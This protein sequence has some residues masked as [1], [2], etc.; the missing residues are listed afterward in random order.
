VIDTHKVMSYDCNH[1][2]HVT[3]SL[4]R[5][6]KHYI[7]VLL[8]SF[9]CHLILFM[10]EQSVW[11]R[12]LFNKDCFCNVRV[13]ANVINPRKTCVMASGCVREVT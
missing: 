8:F 12:N 2:C 9:V 6:G 4:P 3:L 7:K 5:T 10:M 11:D 1:P 13:P